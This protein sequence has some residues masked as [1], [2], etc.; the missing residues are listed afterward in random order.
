MGTLSNS[1]EFLHLRPEVQSAVR[2]KLSQA[3]EGATH[4]LVSM[5]YDQQIKALDVIAGAVKSGL[6]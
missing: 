2:D 5:V 4:T 3:D 1:P 6:T